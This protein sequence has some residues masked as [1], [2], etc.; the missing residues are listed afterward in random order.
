MVWYVMLYEIQGTGISSDSSSSIPRSIKRCIGGPLS[1][2]L[3]HLV[4]FALSH[5]TLKVRALALVYRYPA[6]ESWLYRFSRTRGLITD[7]TTVQI[8]SD[9]SRLTPSALR[10]YADLKAAVERHGKEGQ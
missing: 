8:Y 5:P 1:S 9:L 10:I 3:A 7:S 2:I 4:L 6:L